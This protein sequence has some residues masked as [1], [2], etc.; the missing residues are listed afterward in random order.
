M[1]AEHMLLQTGGIVAAKTNL[2]ELLQEGVINHEPNS[3]QKGFHPVNHRF[4]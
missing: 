4:D 2:N 3:E 1:L